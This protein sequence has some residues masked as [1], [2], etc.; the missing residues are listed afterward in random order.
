MTAISHNPGASPASASVDRPLRI[1]VV[2]VAAGGIGGMQRHTHDL[3]RRLVSFGHDVEVICPRS[4]GLDE[5]LYGARWTLLEAQGRSAPTWEA[6]VVAAFRAAEH[7]G[8]TFD[9]VHSESTSA[10]PLV[11]AQVATP[12]VVKYHGNYVG[13][14]RAH[15]QRALR[16]PTTSPRELRGLL[17]LTRLHFRGG[18]AWAFRTCESIVVSRQ[19]VADTRRS[20]RIDAK[21]MHVV[22]NG[23]DVDLFRPGDRSALR[24][25]FGLADGALLATVGRLNAEK[26]FDV[27]IEAF[28]AIATEHPTSRLLVVGEGEERD[29]LAALA[30]ERGV[31][32]RVDF[33]GRRTQEEVAGLLAASDVFL[34]PTRRD[35]AG[36]LVLPQAMAAGLPVVASRIGGITEV[37]EPGDGSRPGIL[38]APGSVAEVASAIRELLANPALRV[39]IGRAARARAVAGYGLDAMVGRTTAVYR[40]AIARA[41]SAA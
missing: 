32:S 25:G 34:F 23:V 40:L 13:L 3:V 26:G 17:R 20:H 24:A 29:A 9:V 36:P 10:L 4:D 1:L 8:G 35:E 12:V 5:A 2:T 22:P 41:G 38:V 30:A 14:A 11:H 37:L 6:D 15:L 27:A 16:R 33:L 28:A 19:Q 21:R 7:R 31:E 39:E 18:N